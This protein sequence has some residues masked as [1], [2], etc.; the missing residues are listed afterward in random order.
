MR[1][2]LSRNYMDGA[3]PIQCA[4]LMDA[5]MSV[6]H[7]SGLSQFQEYPVQASF[8]IHDIVLL[9]KLSMQAWS[10]KSWYIEYKFQV[11]PCSYTSRDVTIINYGPYD[12]TEYVIIGFNFI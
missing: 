3:I 1:Q 4:I 2:G 8:I 12:Y 11:L 6:R 10:P 7:L 5:M 9:V